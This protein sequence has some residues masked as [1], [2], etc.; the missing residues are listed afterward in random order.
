MSCND[1]CK[2]NCSNRLHAASSQSPALCGGEKIPERMPEFPASPYICTYTAQIEL[3]A[4]TR[5]REIIAAVLW[6]LYA[7]I[8]TPVQLWH[9]HNI[10]KETKQSAK[11]NRILSE[12][13]ST[14][15]DVNCPICH[16]QYSVYND[17]V[18]IPAIP[19]VTEF[20]LQNG[21]YI[22]APL[23]YPSFSFQNKGPPFL[24]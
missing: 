1:L 11:G 23:H 9:H 2:F 5:Y 18:I 3:T 22:P 7:F 19:A 6:V 20:S 24:C 21:H 12:S 8:A 4:S 15:A 13:K 10:A 16:H 17:D 14:T